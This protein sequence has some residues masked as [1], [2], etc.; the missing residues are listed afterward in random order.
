MQRLEIPNIDKEV[1]DIDEV[2]WTD[3]KKNLTNS[4]SESAGGP[5]KIN[6]EETL[7]EDSR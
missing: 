5:S 1:Q 6:E 2:F 4:K 3:L 7:K